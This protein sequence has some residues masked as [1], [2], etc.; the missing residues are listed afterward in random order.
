MSR[1]YA[2][3]DCNNFYVSCER[4][5]NPK[6]VNKPVVVL[7]N[8]DGCVIARSEEAKLLGVE[9]GV[10]FFKIKPFCRQRGIAVCSSNYALYGD[11]AQRVVTIIESLEPCVEVYSI[12]EVFVA[13]DG[14]A[15]INLKKYLTYLQSVIKRWVGIPVSIGVGQT[16]TLAK[17]ASFQAKKR[18][19]QPI[20]ILGQDIAQRFAL[21]TTPVAEVWGIGRRWC[22]RLAHYDINNAFDLSCSEPLFMRQQF[23]VVLA[24]TVRELK[25]QS[26]L[27]LIENLPNK[28]NISS[29]RSFGKPLRDF[30]Q[31]MEALSN[32]C[33]RAAEKLR[34]QHSLATTVQIF[35]RTNAFSQTTP[36]HCKSVQMLLS[37]PTND[38]GYIIQCAKQGLKSIYVAGVDYHKAGVLLGEL[39]NEREGQ[40]LSLFAD[41]EKPTKQKISHNHVTR[42]AKTLDAIN[43][44]FGRDVLYLAS[45]RRHA[46]QEWQMRSEYCSPRYTTRWAELLSVNSG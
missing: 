24:N 43:Q 36:Y 17:I 46:I 15:N 27:D 28:K 35:L 37:E 20:C 2:L 42:A 7:S 40:Q 3:I 41:H 44:R 26:C 22:R 25:G 6:L 30:N 21:E 11:L 13:L 10:P 12:D 45:Q 14:V 8:N 39:I 5:F 4:V 19:K 1:L 31:I 34:Q 32:Y 23:N 9:M 16:K 33:A 29:S 18:L 38:T